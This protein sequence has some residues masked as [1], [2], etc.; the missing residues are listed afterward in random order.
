LERLRFKDSETEMKILFVCHRLP[1][2]PN[3]GGK[4]RPFNMIRHLSQKHSVVVASLAES[5]R[6]LR[7][8]LALRQYCDELI[9]E[10]LPTPIRWVQAWKALLAGEPSSAAYFWSSKLKRRVLGLKRGFDVIFVHCAFVAP[11]VS[12]FD[13]GF[14]VLDFGDIDSAKWFAYSRSKPFPISLGY[15]LEA[16][17]LRNFERR[18]ASH[19]HHCTVTA[20]SEMD[21]FRE[22][23]V[24]VPCT[25]VLNGIDTASFQ[26]APK[27][28]HDHPVIVFVGRMDYFPN[29][30][31]IV[32][33]AKQI[34]P[35]IRQSIPKAELRIVGSSPTRE[36]RKL[37]SRPGISVTGHVPD[38]RP[39]LREAIVSIA[40]LRIARGTQNK[41]LEA[42]AAGVPVVATP[43]AAKGIQAV[44]GEHLLVADTVQA[45]ANHVINVL[46]NAELRSRL[47]ERGRQQ[48]E[49]SHVWP[50]SMEILDNVLRQ[51]RRA[52]HDH[53]AQRRLD[54]APGGNPYYGLIVPHR[55]NRT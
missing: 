25:L 20:Q 55:E 15:R 32:Y 22:L 49:N 29:I 42:M 54:G 50:L 40:P 16:Q 53:G 4:I 21:E 34:L 27:N 37:A 39:Y 52:P 11:Y 23:N 26:P 9:A 17:R 28:I 8:G 30:E 51:I 36:V 41:I 48:I 6:E 46:Q 5:Q 1:F 7:E 19:F 10:V 35:I 18:A 14:R 31:G 33:F 24:G 13:D 47:S 44:P 3:R 43:E 2:P 38:V 12:H 45:F